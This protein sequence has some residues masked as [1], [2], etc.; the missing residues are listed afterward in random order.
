MCA[1]GEGHKDDCCVFYTSTLGTADGARGAEVKGGDQGPVDTLGSSPIVD[2]DALQLKHI[3]S[4]PVLH[5]RHLQ[6]EDVVPVYTFNIQCTISIRDTRLTQIV[7]D[8]I[9]PCVRTDVNEMRTPS[10]MS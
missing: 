10:D 1:Y 5:H 4:Y 7:C 6:C 3:Q 8:N 2:G 9:Y